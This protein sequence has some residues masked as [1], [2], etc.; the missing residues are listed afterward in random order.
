MSKAQQAREGT[1]NLITSFNEFIE[2]EA[3]EDKAKQQFLDRK[4]E[5][6]ERRF[7]DERE[8]RRQ[9]IDLKRKR[10]DEE[11]K[12]EKRKELRELIEKETDEEIRKAYK[13]KLLSYYD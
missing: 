12:R 6:T 3:K 4:L 13:T 8:L 7:E 2:K 5:L 9:E 10:W 11:E 1:K